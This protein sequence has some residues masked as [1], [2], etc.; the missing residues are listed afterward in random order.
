M[1]WRWEAFID[2]LFSWDGLELLLLLVLLALLIP[3]FFL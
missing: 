1:N 3:G 2:F